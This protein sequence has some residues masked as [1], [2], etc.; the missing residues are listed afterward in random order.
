M[1]GFYYIHLHFL[2]INCSKSGTEWKPQPRSAPWQVNLWH[3]LE[4]PNYCHLLILS[5]DIHEVPSVGHSLCWSLLYVP[6]LV[7]SSSVL[8]NPQITTIWRKKNK[9]LYLFIKT[10]KKILYFHPKYIFH[11]HKINVKNFGCTILDS[12]L[13]RDNYI[14]VQY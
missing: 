5:P 1:V 14:H 4:S 2:G 12:F 6:F 11:P 3:L 10:I 8:P 7:S 13:Y 9:N